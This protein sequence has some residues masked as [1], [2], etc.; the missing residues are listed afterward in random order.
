MMFLFMIR[1]K[2]NNPNG[3]KLQQYTWANGWRLDVEGDNI[4]TTVFGYQLVV[5]CQIVQEM[6]YT[7]VCL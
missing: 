4:L 1:I 2:F 3:Y 5:I 6:D 7:F